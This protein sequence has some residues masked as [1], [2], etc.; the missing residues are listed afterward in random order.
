MEG[1]A[2]PS[3]SIFSLGAYMVKL[4]HR[5]RAVPCFSVG[6]LSPGDFHG[7]KRIEVEIS[8]KAYVISLLVYGYVILCFFGMALPALSP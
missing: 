2:S 5:T 6:R 1:F 8:L 4:I 3:H 7:H